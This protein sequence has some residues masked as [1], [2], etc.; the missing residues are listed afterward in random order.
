ML[1]KNRQNNS[2][3]ETSLNNKGPE[4]TLNKLLSDQTGLH[5]FMVYLQ[6][7]YSIELSNCIFYV[8]VISEQK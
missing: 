6:N 2:T 7:E 3:P 8:R 5:L 1:R 4:I